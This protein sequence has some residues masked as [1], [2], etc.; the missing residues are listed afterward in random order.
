MSNR[1]P[2][3]DQINLVAYRLLLFVVLGLAQVATLWLWFWTHF[4]DWTFLEAARYVVNAWPLS[5][6]MFP[7]VMAMAAVWIGFANTA[8]LYLL[9][10][11][12]WKKRSDVL[13]RRGS[14]LSD[15]REEV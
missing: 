8:V 14:R 5:L 6:D 12:W 13:H 7:S 3:L 10:G 11:R 2:L 4:K 15:E 1:D 9:L